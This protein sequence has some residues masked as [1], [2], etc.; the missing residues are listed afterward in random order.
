[1]ALFS[2]CSDCKRWST[3]ART[4]IKRRS[5]IWIS[6]CNCS[7]KPAAKRDKDSAD[8]ARAARVDSAISLRRPRWLSAISARKARSVRSRPSSSASRRAS[9]AG[10]RKHANN[11]AKHANTAPTAATQSRISFK[12]GLSKGGIVGRI[13]PP[14]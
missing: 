11:A 3:V 14:L 9:L 1:L 8:S 6:P 13:T 10:G 7:P 2:V 5:L 4:S 12:S